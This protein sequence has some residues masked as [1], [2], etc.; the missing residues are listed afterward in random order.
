[1]FTTPFAGRLKNHWLLHCFTQRC[2]ICVTNIS[3]DTNRVSSKKTE[4][5]IPNVNTLYVVEGTTSI[6]ERNLSQN[7][8]WIDKGTEGVDHTS[9]FSDTNN[10]CNDFR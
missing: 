6:L 10:Q 4:S 2:Q 9:T 7:K 8:E 5:S 3:E 1:L